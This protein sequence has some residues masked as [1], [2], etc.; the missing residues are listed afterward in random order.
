MSK[1]LPKTLPGK[2][3]SDC[4]IRNQNCRIGNQFSAVMQKTSE[5]L[6][7]AKSAWSLHILT[8]QPLSTCQK[9]LAGQRPENLDLTVALLR[10]EHGW[11]ILKAIVEGGDEPAPKW[12][13][14]I[15]GLVD[16][17]Q[18]KREQLRLKRE[19]ERR[20]QRLIEGRER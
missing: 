19:I 17:N 2:P 18:I 8:K 13:V 12:F 11:E 10:S 9:V 20:E 1:R 4:R 3:S 5:L 16:I 14:E 7:P 6:P 15:A